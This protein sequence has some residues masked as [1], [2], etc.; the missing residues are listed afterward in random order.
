MKGFNV[1][2]AI[3]IFLLAAAS[4][5]F[6]Y[7]LYEKRA[8]L[9]TGHSYFAKQLTE[10]TQKLE[11]NSGTTLS[12]KVT[13]DTLRHDK[14]PKVVNDQLTEFNKLVAAVVDERDALAETLADVSDSIELRSDKSKF[15]RLNAYKGS[16]DTLKKYAASYRSRNDRILNMLVAS[17]RKL[18][19]KKLSTGAL[20]SSSY[21]A[22]YR[23]LDDRIGFW[24][25][26]HN[27]Y[28]SSVG[29]IA[30]AL[31][32]SRPDS[33]ES[34]YASGL[35]ALVT[36]A[37]K[38]E[39]QRVEYHANWKNEERK[40]ADRDSQIDELKKER[41][42]LNATINSQKLDIKRLEKMLGIKPERR[43]IKDGC[44]EA[45]QL[46]RTQKKGRIMEVNTKFGF[47]VISL[48]KKTQVQDYFDYKP[49]NESKTE[50]RK[51][52]VD[53]IIEKGMI[54]TIARDMSSGD[55]EYINKVKI[56]KVEDHCVIAESVD[57]KTGKPMLEGDFAYL[58][59]DE[60]A[61]WAKN[62]K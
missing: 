11:S 41:D 35:T 4:S 40:V 12:D 44:A 20:K 19:T 26:R 43:A 7:F 23:E 57:R 47:V 38:V 60:I 5:V 45:L 1:F 8:S 24:A 13:T 39:N 54:L 17:G 56:V 9:V 58:A 32:A 52:D 18:G 28:V 3:V 42:Q 62:R 29:Q 30:S 6:S 22:S 16:T 15:T 21:A 53:P 33:S 50:V 27:T 37:R 59:D 55:A 51:W 49:T 34:K 10:A 48:G 25:K 14:S 61:K 2:L 36:H 46:L 31:K